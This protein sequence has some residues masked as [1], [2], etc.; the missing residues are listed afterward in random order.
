MLSSVGRRLQRNLTRNSL[1][2]SPPSQPDL[3]PCE[4]LGC[5]WGALGHTQPVHP[6]TNPLALGGSWKGLSSQTMKEQSSHVKFLWA[7]DSVLRK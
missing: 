5:D 6:Q 4:A 2:A 7:Q 3:A 1:P